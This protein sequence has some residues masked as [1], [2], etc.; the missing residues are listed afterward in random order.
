[1]SNFRSGIITVLLILGIITG[2]TLLLLTSRQSG[3]HS[4]LPMIAIVQYNN[5][6]LSDLTEEGIIEGLTRSGLTKGKD[7]LLEIYN[8]QG[9]VSTLNLIFDAL[10]NDKPDLIF[11]TSTPT[12]QVAVKKIRDIPVVFTMVADPVLAGAGTSYE[13]HLPNVTGISTMGDYEGMV[14]LLTLFRPEIKKIGTIYT[15]GE[16]NSVRNTEVLKKSADAAGI[17]LITIP[18]SSTA[19]VPD[20]ALALASKQ[21]NLVC[22]VADNL[23]AASVA[24]IIKVSGDRNLP[25]FGFVTDQAEKGA[26]LVLAR[27]FKQAGIDAAGLAKKIWEG[28]SPGNIP[29]GS[30]SRT[31]LLINREAAVKTGISIPQEIL[32]KEN[33][34]LVK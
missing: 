4:F 24:S 29:F 12:L 16:I 31:I 22:Q 30:V 17:E 18:V 13:A 9:D 26:V 15:P 25:V 5:T 28:T 32:N 34:I 6:V 3:Y 20:A 27:D 11:V 19:E 23:T 7:Y 14:K 33:V 21:L 1:M 10:V 8:A 2:I